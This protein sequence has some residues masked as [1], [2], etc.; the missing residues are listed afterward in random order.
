MLQTDTRREIMFFNPL[1]VR[2]NKIA[3][4]FPFYLLQ[5]FNPLKVRANKIVANA[6]KTAGGFFNPLKVRANKMICFVVIVML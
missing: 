1:K 2:A 5:F 6:H 3:L 4:K